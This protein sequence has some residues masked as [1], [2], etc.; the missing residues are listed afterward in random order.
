MM[1]D[2][3][4]A[5]EQ[6]FRS[7]SELYASARRTKELF[8]TAGLPL[9]DALK[10]II[11]MNEATAKDS[12]RIVIPPPE[13]RSRPQGVGPGWIAVDIADSTPLTIV[14]AV[15]RKQ[16]SPIRNKDL[17][18]NVTE[19]LPQVASGSVTNTLSRLKA[20]GI[21]DRVDDGWVLAKPESAAVIHDGKLWGPSSVFQKTE[22]ASHRRA[23]IVYLLG[24]FP[25]GLQAL[26]IT[27]HLHSCEWLHAP[28]NKDLVK[29]D[30]QALVEDKKIR[31]RGNTKKYELAPER[32]AA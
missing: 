11:G 3:F 8:E 16:A 20:P 1:D 15:L 2:R 4:G 32:E 5:E 14:P 7:L 12:Q 17:V 19:L 25:S 13:V 9:P 23:V 22:I 18:A 28:V 21:I 10:R 29:M 27:E 26:Q 24:R 31:R 30:L 6:A